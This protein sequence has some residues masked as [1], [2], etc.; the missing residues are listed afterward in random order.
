LGFGGVMGVRV[1]RGGPT[2]GDTSSSCSDRTRAAAW[3]A[4]PF[5]AV[6][7]ARTLSSV[8]LY[9]P[10]RRPSPLP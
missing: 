5:P 2:V 8:L 4:L 9:P 1:Q 10:P 3:A 7:L 6:S